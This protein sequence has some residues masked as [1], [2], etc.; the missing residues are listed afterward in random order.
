[1]KSF[2]LLIAGICCMQ[3]IMAQGKSD[4]V[5]NGEYG[6]GFPDDSFSITPDTLWFITGDDFVYGKQFNI[7]NPH[8]Y[9]INI[10]HIE[11]SG[12]PCS[13]C[14]LWYTSTG[15]FV[16]PIAIAAGGSLPVVVKFVITDAAA[17][18]FFYDTLNMNTLGHSGY[19]IIAADSS[20]TLLG[21]A[22]RG[23][24]KMVV[25]P[26]PFTDRLKI[27]LAITSEPS[28]KL[29]IY[30]ALMQ[31]VKELF[32]GVISPGSNTI[33]WDGTDKEG[34]NLS[35]GIYFITLTTKSGQKTLKVVK[36]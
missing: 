26:N 19:V 35:R 23:R 1:M 34:N 11:S 12:F 20:S 8:N 32:P 10:Q 18:S 13:Y 14:S 30:N 3:F 25:A 33:A 9:P 24:E 29:M 16:S 7:V 28:V 4:S 5:M 17:G 31:S 2:F 22:E 36:L 27:T 21:M 15:A 6:N